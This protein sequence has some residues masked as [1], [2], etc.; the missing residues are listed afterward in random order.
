LIGAVASTLLVVTATGLTAPPEPSDLG[1]KVVVNNGSRIPGHPDRYFN[2]YNPPSVNAGGLVV[3]RAKSTGRQGGPVSGVFTRDMAVADASI[4]KIAD[5]DTQVPE[6]NNTE[7]PAPGGQGENRLATY[8]EFPS[9]PRIAIDADRVATRGNH[10][11]V[12]TYVPGHNGNMADEDETRVGTTGVY[13]NLGAGDPSLSPLVTGASLLGQATG[14]PY[15]DLVYLFRVPGI[16]PATRF[17]VFPGSPAVTDA[18]VIVFKGNY[19]VP[20]PDPDVTIGKTGVFYRTV[21]T[22]YAGGL[23]PI[24]AIATSETPVPNPGVCP[25]GTTF[26]S[27][28]PP[29]AVGQTVVFVGLDNEDSPSCGGIYRASL[30]SDPV[31]LHTLVGIGAAVPGLD[32]ETFTRIGEGL[33]Y[34]GRFVGFWGA[35][36]DQTRTLRLYCPQE[37]NKDRRDFCNHAGDYAPDPVTGEIRGDPRSVCD[38]TGDPR[39]PTCYQEK[40][41]AV[42]QGI[43]VYDTKTRKLRLLARTGPESRFDDFVYWKYSGAPPGAGHG[44]GHAEPPRFRSSAYVTVFRRA[45]ATFRTVFLARN[46]AFDAD[47]NTY[48]DPVDG[49]YLTETV[50]ASATRLT[51]LVR[52]GMD[53]TLLDAA[54]VWDDDDNPATPA[55]PLPVAELALEREALRGSWL[56]IGASMGAEDGDEAGWAGL[57]VTELP[58]PPTGQ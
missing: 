35:W 14:S 38:D 24:A 48:V 13:V 25:A 3:F 32:G 18:G 47:T 29:S 56:A 43:L 31:R 58:Q 5:R 37:G 53:G 46:A 10:E 42:N 41:V 34:D 9:F 11:P 45:G 26:G 15:V 33:A 36:G 44:E 49:V 55:V 8:N 23:Q 28:A 16:E 12:W 4:Q 30:A 19:T 1:W 6:P 40:A 52:T 50:G 22:D 39:H 51:T 57:Y 54:A 20:G 17:D 21:V 27:T 7:Y 2:S